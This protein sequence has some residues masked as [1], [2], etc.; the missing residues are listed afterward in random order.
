MKRIL[1]FFFS[2]LMF[3][4]IAGMASH[5]LNVEFGI[6]TVLTTMSMVVLTFFA[7]LHKRRLNLSEIAKADIAFEI[8]LDYILKR[9]WKD[10][11]FM[12]N[13]YSD[14]QYV[15]GGK[16]V[17]IP[18]PGAKPSVVKNPASWPLTASQRTDSKASYDLDFYVTLP[19]HITNAEAQEVGYD[20]MDSVLG[21]HLGV[22]NERIAEEHLIKMLDV[23]PASNVIYTTGGPTA[24]A[25]ASKITGQTGNRLVFHYLDLKRAQT[26]LNLGNI[27]K[28]NRN[29]ILDSN[30]L[31]EFTSTLSD[32]QMNAFNQYYNAETGQIGRLYGFD[33]FERSDVGT[34]KA[35]LSSG[36]LA[37]NA[38]G[39]AVGATDLAAN[40]VYQKDCA[41]RAMGEIDMY[42]SKKNPLYAGDIYNAS[43]RFGGRRRYE[44]DNGV[45]AIVQGT[46]A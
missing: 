22:I 32:T 45:L 6:P 23:L 44:N 25:T 37:V 39:G 7:V 1:Q 14:D 40:L 11:A 36:K 8:W 17:H 30:S 26:R 38:Y 19:T 42:E 16:T 21:D 10:N 29:I 41:T 34:S 9:F 13:F 4:F 46:P 18:Q 3:G 15:V 31:D 35:A 27:Q 5:Q 12:K 20:K 2:L 43:I 33:I 28:V 24:L